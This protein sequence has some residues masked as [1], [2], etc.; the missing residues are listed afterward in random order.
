MANIFANNA[1]VL[2][3]GTFAVSATTL[4]IQAGHGVKVPVITAPDV[5]YIGLYSS[6][7]IVEICEITAHTV[8]A[9]SM[10]VVR[11]QEGTSEYEWVDGDVGEII[12]TAQVLNQWVTHLHDTQY[13]AIDHLHAG[14]YLDT[15]NDAMTGALLLNPQHHLLGSEDAAW[16]A[17]SVLRREYLSAATTSSDKTGNAIDL[18]VIGGDDLKGARLSG[19][20]GLFSWNSF[21]TTAY[22][23]RAYEASFDYGAGDFFVAGW[24]KS[25]TTTAAGET[26]LW[27]GGTT[28]STLGMIELTVD[29]TSKALEITTRNSAETAVTNTTTTTDI[30]TQSWFFLVAQRSSG[31]LQVYVNGIQDGSNVASALDVTPLVGD[32]GQSPLIIGR[33]TASSN[34][35]PGD[36]AL[37]R[38]GGGA[39]SQADITTIYNAEVGYFSD[40]ATRASSANLVRRQYETF[41]IASGYPGDTLPDTTVLS[42]QCT[43]GFLL[44]TDMFKC[45]F[46]TN[47]QSVDTK[48]LG[49]YKNTT[50]IGTVTF[51]G[52]GNT[53]SAIVFPAAETF[54]AGDRLRVITPAAGTFTDLFITLY[55][56]RT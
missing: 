22:L 51:N 8:A 43:K 38:I 49:I 52:T 14:D 19:G 3:S 33:D 23:Y 25:N 18:T 40:S 32:Q 9:D 42:Y 21:S 10:T 55:A 29:A 26:L 24:F 11:G 35:T 48:V 31:N 41:D 44:Q 13:A 53:P 5:A 16:L 45:Q 46:Y 17:D 6:D 15:A 2:V 37:W 54:V 56:W 12:L 34:F 36:M 27:R 20:T 4:N 39:L 47:S 7:G 30:M 28:T 50:S 1:T